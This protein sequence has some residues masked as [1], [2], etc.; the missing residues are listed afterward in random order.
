MAD[1]I[2]APH[3]LSGIEIYRKILS[4]LIAE[5]LSAGKD[6]VV[7]EKTIN[8]NLHNQGFTPVEPVGSL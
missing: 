5:L 8:R 7:S 3:K 4:L 1:P 2:K 6:F